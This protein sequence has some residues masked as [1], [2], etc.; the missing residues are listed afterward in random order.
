MFNRL[1]EEKL[2]TQNISL[3]DLMSLS[4]L[5]PTEV[6]FLLKKKFLLIK[7][8]NIQFSYTLFTKF[9]NYCKLEK[10]FFDSYINIG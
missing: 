10:D 5:L 2:F 6:K 1:K 9:M 3:E 4:K 7:E 8:I